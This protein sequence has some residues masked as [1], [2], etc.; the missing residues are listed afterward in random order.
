MGKGKRRQERKEDGKG[1]SR[2]G[3]EVQTDLDVA[4]KRTALE[5]PSYLAALS[6]TNYVL[7]VVAQPLG[8]SVSSS[9]KCNW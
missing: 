1:R 8:G 9:I 4:P 7:W 3:K 5:P 6:P 2:E